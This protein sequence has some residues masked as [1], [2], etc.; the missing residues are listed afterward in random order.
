MFLSLSMA[1][2]MVSSLEVTSKAKKDTA[3]KRNAN[4]GST[5]ASADTVTL[6]GWNNPQLS[7]QG[8][9]EAMRDAMIPTASSQFRLHFLM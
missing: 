9:S 8:F 7:S 2:S 4:S 3:W 5:C 1:G 6:T